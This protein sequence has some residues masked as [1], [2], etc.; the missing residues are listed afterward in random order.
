MR[1]NL[2]AAGIEPAKA[3]QFLDAVDA[4]SDE[5]IVAYLEALDTLRGEDGAYK[6]FLEVWGL[7]SPEWWSNMAMLG[8]TDLREH[9]LLR[10]LAKRLR[11]EWRQLHGNA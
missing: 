1:P 7:K 8:E 11:R 5:A 3:D 6:A 4:K 10:P 2:L 9:K